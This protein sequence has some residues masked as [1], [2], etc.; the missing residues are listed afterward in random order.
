MMIKR[1]DIFITKRGKKAYEVVG[2]TGR[3]IVLAPLDEKDEECLIYSENEI[4]EIFETEED[5]K[6]K[7]EARALFGRKI[8]DLKEL[9]SLT[10][11]AL[12]EGKKGKAYTVNKE[13]ELEGKDF[14]KFAANFLRDQPW[15]E[16]EDTCI[17]VKNKETGETV[18]VDPQGYE[19]PRYV[20]LEIK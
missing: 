7:Q 12:R 3:D 15:I 6:P 18:L 2:R 4:L 8:S 10:E 19:Y 13:V 11:Q 1:K 16:K 14:Q 9:K 20:S 5:K 17:R